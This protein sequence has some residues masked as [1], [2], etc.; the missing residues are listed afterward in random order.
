MLI[1][2]VLA[3]AVKVKTCTVVLETIVK[4]HLYSITPISEQSWTWER[5]IDEQD[6]ARYSIEG[7]CGVHKLEVVLIDV[8]Y[9][10]L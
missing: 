3:N 9:Y 2:I 7:S 5:A 4:C 6:V 1:C 10:S 8:S